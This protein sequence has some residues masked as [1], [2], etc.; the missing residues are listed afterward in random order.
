MTSEKAKALESA[1]AQIERQFGRGTIMPLGQ[2]TNLVQI[3]AIPTGSLALDLALGIGGIPKGR[4][5][6]V[7]G[8]ESSGKTTL[9]YHAM[10]NAQRA[11]G[12]AAYID[13]EHTLD[14]GYTAT[15]E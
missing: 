4:V 3:D 7:F 13:A 8:V 6:E 5:T 10:A 9:T 15:C 11:G 1:V 12:T 2:K 14:P